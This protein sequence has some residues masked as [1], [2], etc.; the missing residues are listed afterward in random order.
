MQVPVLKDL[1]R[2]R[3]EGRA[4]CQKLLLR[5]KQADLAQRLEGDDK[6]QQTAME[7]SESD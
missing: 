2:K 4:Q 5:G 3:N 1:I 7:S 6:K